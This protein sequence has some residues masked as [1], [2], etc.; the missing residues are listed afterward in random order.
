MMINMLAVMLVGITTMYTTKY[1]IEHN[2]DYDVFIV[3][4]V[5]SKF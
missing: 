3:A 5:S 2:S 1:K 4:K